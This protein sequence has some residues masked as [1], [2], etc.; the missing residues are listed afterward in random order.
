MGIVS[1][2]ALNWWIYFVVLQSTTPWLLKHLVFTNFKLVLLNVDWTISKLIK[3]LLGTT[4]CLDSW[5][6]K[7]ARLVLCILVA[8][9]I[10]S[11]LL[12]VSIHYE[13]SQRTLLE[14]KAINCFLF[15]Y[16]IFCIKLVVTCQFFSL[17]WSAS[18]GN[19]QTNHNWEN[20]NHNY[21]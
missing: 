10:D 16:L 9:G 2:I 18:H 14:L 21:C 3:F 7:E 13:K 19:E 17:V 12:L 1:L 6:E 4:I 5:L 15:F 8:M 11:H 20:S